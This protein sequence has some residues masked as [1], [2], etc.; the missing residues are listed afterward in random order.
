MV[1]IQKI[2]IFIPN[3]T[4]ARGNNKYK[5]GYSD[6]NI[7]FYSYRYNFVQQQIRNTVHRDWTRYRARGFWYKLA[8][9]RPG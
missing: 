4:I 3:T 8:A 9:L 7:N 6:V 5:A 1:F 2:T